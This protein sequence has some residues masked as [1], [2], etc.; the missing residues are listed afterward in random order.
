M[1]ST[2]YEPTTKEYF[3]RLI[4]TALNIA[5]NERPLSHFLDLIDLQKKNGFKFLE[6]KSYKQPSAK[7]ID[8]L[9]EIY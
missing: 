7:F 3:W 9:A 6:D 1:V 4:V 2:F 5:L 8:P